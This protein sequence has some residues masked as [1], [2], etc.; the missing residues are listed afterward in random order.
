M[1]AVLCS[2]G[3][4]KLWNHAL[5][6]IAAISHSWPRLVYIINN[7]VNTLTVNDNACAVVNNFYD[8]I[9]FP[10]LIK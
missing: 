9:N 6:I 8:H 2:F 5:I 3:N 7:Q 4:K 1:I 10:T